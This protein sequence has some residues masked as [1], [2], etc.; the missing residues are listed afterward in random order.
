MDAVK[1]K[2]ALTLGQDVIH[3]KGTG[4]PEGTEGQ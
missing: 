4:S 3:V 2:Q 1:G